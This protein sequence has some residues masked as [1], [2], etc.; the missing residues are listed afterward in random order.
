MDSAPRP[1][2]QVS[3]GVLAVGIGAFSLLQ[4]L[5]IPV[6]STVQVELHT[7][8]SAVTWVLTAYLLS[9]SVMTPILGR[10][11]DI[12]GKKWVFVAALAALAVGSVLA[13]LAPNLGVLVVARV[14]QGL[15]GG[16]L[17]LGFGIIRDEF[18]ADKVAGAVGI[19][20]ALTAVGGSLGIVLAG[21]I[22]NALNWHWLFWLPGIATVVAA[23]GAV[24]FVPQPPIRSPGTISWLPAVLLTG[25]LVALLVPL[26]ARVRADPVLGWVRVRRQHRPFWS[27]AAA[28]R[29]SPCSR[30]AC[31][32]GPSPGGSAARPWW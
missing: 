5:V 3:F 27:D 13:A 30:W 9:A 28:P 31:S 22:V 16:T 17:P 10:V 18:P 1:H 8:Q 6:L 32:W 14:I 26:P 20:A 29:G 7:S 12:Y 21:P 19:L 4:S 2:Y 23:L 11:G 24:L 15:G 25:W